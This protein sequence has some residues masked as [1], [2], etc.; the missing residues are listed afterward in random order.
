MYN[1][2]SN[3]RFGYF[4]LFLV[5]AVDVDHRSP[6][7]R[8]H[9]PARLLSLRH[10]N[11]QVFSCGGEVQAARGITQ[12]NDF[13]LEDVVWPEAIDHDYLIDQLFPNVLLPNGAFNVLAKRDIVDLYDVHKS[14]I[15]SNLADLSI[16][17][18]TNPDIEALDGKLIFN[19]VSI[20]AGAQHTDDRCED[21]VLV[22]IETLLKL[23]L[24][25]FA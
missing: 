20:I 24:I 18:V 6:I 5:V 9:Q 19:K 4:S 2:H 22:E 21:K 16:Y 8:K 17:D 25:V 12:T 1:N 11:S 23:L 7:V 10:N 14:L 15:L 13:S 3:F